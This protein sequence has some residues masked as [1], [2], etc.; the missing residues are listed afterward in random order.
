MQENI[1][2]SFIKAQIPNPRC[3][4]IEYFSCMSDLV[5]IRYSQLHCSVLAKINIY[6]QLDASRLDQ[7][8]TLFL[9][10]QLLDIR[11]PY[12]CTNIMLKS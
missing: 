9:K 3:Y 1:Y 10:K 5:H 7:E 11:L 8:F 2:W 12:V 6:L 4:I